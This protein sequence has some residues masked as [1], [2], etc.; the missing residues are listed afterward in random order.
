M[1]T[2]ERLVAD[3]NGTGLTM[4]HTNGIPPRGD[5]ECR[6]IPAAGLRAIQ[7]GVYGEEDI[8]S[9][10]RLLRISRAAKC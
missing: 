1:T 4:G 2:E 9:F 8:C 7:D 6:I 10:I 5:E 3:F